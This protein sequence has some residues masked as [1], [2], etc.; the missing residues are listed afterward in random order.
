MYSDFAKRE[1]TPQEILL[2]EALKDAQDI[3]QA[4][5]DWWDNVKP[6]EISAYYE[7]IV[8]EEFWKNATIPQLAVLLDNRVD[9]DASD[10]NGKTALMYACQYC[11]STD[12]VRWYL[13]FHPEVHHKDNNGKSAQDYALSNQTLAKC[14]DIIAALQFENLLCDSFWKTATSETQ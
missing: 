9:R 13:N 11:L 4:H 3:P 8:S 5:E 14:A 1:K 7:S 10:K 6:E 2:E 12:V